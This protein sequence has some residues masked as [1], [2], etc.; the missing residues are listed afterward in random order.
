MVNG[1]VCINQTDIAAAAHPTIGIETLEKTDFSLIK[2]QLFSTKRCKY[3]INVVSLQRKPK[4]TYTM[5]NTNK[6]EMVSKQIISILTEAASHAGYCWDGINIEP[7]TA[8]TC[9][10][11]IAIATG[12]SYYRVK[13]CIGQLIEA[14]RITITRHKYFSIITICATPA[15]DKQHE[16][17]AE[18]AE[19]TKPTVQVPGNQ[20]AAKAQ[21]TSAMSTPKT[22]AIQ[23]ARSTPAATK[24]STSLPPTQPLL[25]RA[26]RRR[27]ARQAAKDE[28]R[29]AK[30]I[31]S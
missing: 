29:R 4:K 24:Q 30:R 13:K 6:T 8:V 17:S 3:S 5:K 14:G 10:K 9:L 21:K 22:S 12:L 7:G 18:T 2:I 19:A 26:A 1:I 23:I 27:L 11:T 16:E 20:G 15:H 28:A 25:N 31:R